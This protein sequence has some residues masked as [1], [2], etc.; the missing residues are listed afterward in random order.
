[1][2]RLH[3]CWLTSLFLM[4]RLLLF[5]ACWTIPFWRSFVP[6][7]K[8]YQQAVSRCLKEQ[9]RTV[10]HWRLTFLFV[11]VY[12]SRAY[13]DIVICK[14]LYSKGG[15]RK[16][17]VRFTGCCAYPI[18]SLEWY[19]IPFP[20]TF[21]LSCSTTFCF[22]KFLSLKNLLSIIVHCWNICLTAMRRDDIWLA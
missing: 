17:F 19:T 5:C 16:V 12:V 4:V 9:W 18:S 14:H 7:N 13:H 8:K 1:M 2:L 21:L 11:F 3:F 15:K 22:V 20:L 6:F 10:P